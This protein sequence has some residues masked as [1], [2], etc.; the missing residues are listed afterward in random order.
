MTNKK[1]NIAETA[2]LLKREFD[3]MPRIPT[4]HDRSRKYA[5][6][7]SSI[8]SDV[9]G[10]REI[11]NYMVCIRMCESIS[12]NALLTNGSHDCVLMAAIVYLSYNR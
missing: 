1:I 2:T 7:P 9:C 4:I 8:C 11:L 5:I 3:T 10:R 12:E 6:V